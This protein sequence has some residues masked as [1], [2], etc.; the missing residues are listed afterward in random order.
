MKPKAL[1]EKE[2]L[3]ISCQ[4]CCKEIFIYTHPVLY[5]CPADIVVDFYRARGF[6]ITRLR[7]DALIL[8]LK[9]TCP[10]LT[11]EGCDIYEKRP[12]ACVDYSGIED[13]GD[14][15]LWSTLK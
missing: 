11:A 5:S 13:F 4:K 3:C 8:S 7:E 9:H 2:R 14:G 15:C 6:E 12:Q 10:H 1:S